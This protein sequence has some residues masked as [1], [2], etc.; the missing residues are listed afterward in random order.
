M[1]ESEKTKL[2]HQQTRL[3][4][5]VQNELVRAQQ[6]RQHWAA[7]E[8]ELSARAAKIQESIDALETIPS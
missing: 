6:E 2:I 8:A 1:S 3:L 4:T 7:R 5:D